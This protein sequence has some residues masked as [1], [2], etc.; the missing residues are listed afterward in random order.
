ME[1]AGQD[2]SKTINAEMH[3]YI[4]ESSE[5]ILINQIRILM[6]DFSISPSK[7]WSEKKETRI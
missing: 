4:N 3:L 7:I 2:E 5:I 1:K 6:G